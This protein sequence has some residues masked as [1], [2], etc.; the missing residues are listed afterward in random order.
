MCFDLLNRQRRGTHLILM[1]KDPILLYFFCI[2]IRNIIF[3][4]IA[5]KDN[6]K[7]TELG[8][9]SFGRDGV[10]PSLRNED[11]KISK[12]IR[13]TFSPVFVLPFLPESSGYVSRGVPGNVSE[14]NCEEPCEERPRARRLHSLPR[15]ENSRINNKH[16]YLSPYRITSTLDPIHTRLFCRYINIGLRQTPTLA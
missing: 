13:Y 1:V 16:K 9:V 6:G 12:T 11:K 8:V 7:E 3:S 15:Y 5:F 10:S 4:H 14:S 2:I